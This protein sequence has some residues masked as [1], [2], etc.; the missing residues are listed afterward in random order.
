MFSSQLVIHTTALAE[1]IADVNALAEELA[2]A[3]EPQQLIQSMTN[4]TR[5]LCKNP[6][7]AATVYFKDSQHTIRRVYPDLIVS[8]SKGLV[9]L[10]VRDNSTIRISSAQEVRL[11]RLQ[12]TC[13]LASK[14]IFHFALFQD[15]AFDKECDTCFPEVAKTSVLYLPIHAYGDT[16]DVIGMLLVEN[17]DNQEFPAADEEILR[18]F[19]LAAEVSLS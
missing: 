18:K 12:I 19:C 17:S 11:S 9:G 6:V 8:C 14:F 5:Q 10:T 15:P 13:S 3:T 7:S 4:H 1:L 16:N 2:K